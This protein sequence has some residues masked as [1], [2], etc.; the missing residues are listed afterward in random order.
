M[1]FAIPS[2]ESSLYNHFAKA[3]QIML[4]DSE[5]NSKRTL[6]L[7]Q[8][9]ARC[10]HKKHWIQVLKDHQVDAVVV[11]L[12]GTNMLN[13][14][15]ELNVR[16]LSAPRGFDLEAFD[17]DQLTAVTQIEFARPSAKTNKISCSAHNIKHSP[18]SVTRL[19]SNR[20]GASGHQVPINKLSPRIM[21][22]LAKILK[23]TAQSE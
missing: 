4:W 2:R 21:C 19:S 20:G 11:R 15:F 6:E 17:V 9:S 12:I 8:S 13:T 7:P 14:L 10:R 23:L 18:S 3:P 5:T 16:V 22:R 1:L